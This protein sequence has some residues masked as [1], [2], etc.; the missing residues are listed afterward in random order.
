MLCWSVTFIENKLELEASN[1]LRLR[2]LTTR[3]TK[4]GF[5]LRQILLHNYLDVDLYVDVDMLEQSTLLLF[6]DS[7]GS[8]YQ[9][10]LQ[11]WYFTHKIIENYLLHKQEIDENIIKL[12]CLIWTHIRKFYSVTTY[13]MLHIYISH[14]PG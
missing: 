14:F 12:N 5:C 13:Y 9:S 7:N 2:C 10:Y 8:S 6:N 11:N 1:A 4:S 3:P